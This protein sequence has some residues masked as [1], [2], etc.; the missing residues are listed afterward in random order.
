MQASLFS[1]NKT[2]AKLVFGHQ[3]PNSLLEFLEQQI[4]PN[5]EAERCLPVDDEVGQARQWL[6]DHAQQS[7]CHSN[8]AAVVLGARPLGASD[9]WSMQLVRPDLAPLAAKGVRDCLALT[10]PPP[11]AA[12]LEQLAVFLDR[13]AEQRNA[14]LWVVGS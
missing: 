1:L 12:A 14:L 9:L 4:L 13:A 3:D 7:P 10:P 6:M 11:H 8:A 2:E 5:L